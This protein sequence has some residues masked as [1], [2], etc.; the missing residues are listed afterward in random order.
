MPDLSDEL[1]QAADDA[2][3]QARPAAVADVI[4]RGNRRRHSA[5]AQRSIGGLSLA[6]IAVAAILTGTARS[7]PAAP[8]AG[9]ATASSTQTLTETTSST[10]G[11]L[12]V[13]VR[14][15]DKPRGKLDILSVNFSGHSHVK[16]KNAVLAITF[17]P[18]PGAYPQVAI[19]WLSLLR[20]GQLAGFSGSVPVKLLSS[21]KGLNNPLSGTTI[22][23][24]LQAT[25]PKA[26]RPGQT[27]MQEA[28]T[29]Y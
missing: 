5:I 12:T 17:R 7:T 2:A 29:L 1:R 25:N 26:T 21:G 13:V 20:P 19:S 15:R 9:A 10:A 18:P 6:G 8:A 4:R 27:I 28:M 22:R 14:Y 16:V 3:R 24:A 11:N 23:T